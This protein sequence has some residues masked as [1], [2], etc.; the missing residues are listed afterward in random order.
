MHTDIWH[1]YASAWSA[2]AEQRRALL[3]RHLCPQITYRDPATE[4]HGRDA[5]SDYMHAFQESFPEHR[6]AI[7]TVAAHHGHSLAHWQLRDPD[8]AP[9]Q[10][11]IS[12]GIH[13]AQHRLT[14]ITGFFP[15]DAANA[16][17]AGDGTG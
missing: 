7:I 10:A 12:H 3:D 16:Q 6:F 11:G 9:I 5:L 17:P 8:D 4:V 13:D 2:P 14:D 1:A 15:T